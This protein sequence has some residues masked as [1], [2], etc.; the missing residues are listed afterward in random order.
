MTHYD[1]TDIS[2]ELNR[3]T[4]DTL[5]SL[6]ARCKSGDISGIEFRAAVEAL[7]SSVAGLIRPEFQEILDEI[8]NSLKKETMTYTTVFLKGTTPISFSWT[9]GE[10][11]VVTQ[12]MSEGG[13]VTRS[14]AC[15]EPHEAHAR[16]VNA[17]T[18]AT[19]KYGKPFITCGDIDDYRA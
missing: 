17:V 5:S 18:Q 9:C 12:W 2:E 4:I 16:Y 8:L 13:L 11:K 10:Y 3:K 1:P 14:Y 6:S 15:N 7:W 19:A